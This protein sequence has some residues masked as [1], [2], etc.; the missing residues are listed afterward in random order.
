MILGNFGEMMKQAKEL[1]QNL[2]KLKDELAHLKY[3]AEAGGVK[4]VVNGEMEIL[5]I[6]AAPNAE[7]KN[8]KEAANRALKQAKDD[9]AEKLKKAAGGLSLPGLM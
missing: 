1:Q 5:D 8:I 4:V 6:K 2:K 9:A 3:E 7:M